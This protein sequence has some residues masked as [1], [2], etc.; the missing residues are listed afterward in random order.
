MATHSCILA[1]KIPWTKEPGR[2][3]SMR[4]QRVRRNWVTEH[5]HKHRIIVIIITTTNQ[6]TSVLLV[7]AWIQSCPHELTHKF[8]CT[9]HH[10]SHC[11]L[12]CT[13]L[14]ESPPTIPPLPART[15]PSGCKVCGS[16]H[17]IHLCVNANK[18]CMYTCIPWVWGVII[19]SQT[20]SCFVSFWWVLDIVSY[21]GSGRSL[22]SAWMRT[23]AA[24]CRV[25]CFHTP[26]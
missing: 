9:S 25:F 2:L 19:P 13:C 23:P 16:F 12:L 22:I 4:S 18:W 1:W 11:L 20:V 8:P 17:V 15:L 24:F 6:L 5:T 10:T 14:P 26:L 3:Q 7:T 21:A